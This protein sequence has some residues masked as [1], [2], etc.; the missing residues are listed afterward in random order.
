MQRGQHGQ[1]ASTSGAEIAGSGAAAAAQI[2]IPS[3]SHTN[4]NPRSAR[5]AGSSK[6]SGSAFKAHKLCVSCGERRSNV[7]LMPC[8]HMVLC[9]SCAD[10][11]S[12]PSCGQ[13]CKQRVRVHQS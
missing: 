12:C 6:P 2:T 13:P 9:D 4:A 10:V 3:G 8:K 1:A 7:L 11:D 5:Q